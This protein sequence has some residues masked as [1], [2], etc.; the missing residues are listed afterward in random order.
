MYGDGILTD[1]RIG[2]AG[3]KLLAGMY[4]SIA[5]LAAAGIDVIVDNVIHDRR[6]LKAVVAALAD[7]RVLFVG[8]KLPQA[9]TEQ[10]E[11][12]RG[13]RGPGGALAFY[14]LVHAHAIYDL[15]LD[16]ALASPLECAEQIK[17]AVQHGPPHRA[18]REMVQPLRP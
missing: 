12:D 4:R 9:V 6:E 8:L 18:I 5:A 15:E 1:V 16:T 17:Q 13:D 14:D 11:R 10:R 7:S 2:P 3:L